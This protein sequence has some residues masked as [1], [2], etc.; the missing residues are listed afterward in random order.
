MK[1]NTQHRPSENTNRTG[2]RKFLSF[3]RWFCKSFLSMK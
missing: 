2:I 1:F 3:K